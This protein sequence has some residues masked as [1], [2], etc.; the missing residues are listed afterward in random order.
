D[1]REHLA[2]LMGLQPATLTQGKMTYDLRRLRLHGFVE[3]IPGTHRYQVTDF[4]F[5]AALVLHRAHVRLLRPALAA[6]TGN[7]GP[8]SLRRALHQCD[9]AVEELLST[10]PLAA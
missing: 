2:P 8:S 9:L 5:H 4:G 3:R 1:L 6:A 7:C 10:T